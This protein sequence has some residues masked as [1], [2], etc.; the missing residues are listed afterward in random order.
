MKSKSLFTPVLAAGA[1]SAAVAAAVVLRG[2]RR[3]AKGLGR[4]HRDPNRP[5]RLAVGRRSEVA[6][7]T[8]TASQIYSLDSPG[9]VSITATSGEGADEGT[10]IVLNQKGLILTNDHVVAGATSLSIKTGGSS[11]TTQ[12][13]HARR[14][15]SQHATSP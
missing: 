12:G 5:E 1:I 6:N 13:C 14:R 3:L 10:G 8:L 9:V 4:P 11:G 2:G 7:T 15:G